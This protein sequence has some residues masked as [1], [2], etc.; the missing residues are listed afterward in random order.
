M[1]FARPRLRV[2]RRYDIDGATRTQDHN[3]PLARARPASPFSF[4]G[5]A[6]IAAVIPVRMRIDSEH[7]VDAS[8]DSTSRSANNPTNK[9][10]DRSEHAVAGISTAVCP[11]VHPTRHALRLCI[12][13]R[14]E[15]ETNS[16]HTEH[17]HLVS[18][19]I[20]AAKSCITIL[21]VVRLHPGTTPASAGARRR[22]RQK[23]PRHQSRSGR[24]VARTGLRDTVRNE[25]IREDLHRSKTPMQKCRGG[26]GRSGGR[27]P[28]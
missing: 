21:A 20:C 15:K 6:P 28:S 13:R 7:A 4:R 26:Q 18:L 11:V 1:G 10:T 27:H 14:G 3:A 8:N 16:N 9:A 19:F 2:H 23:K 12:D 17:S 5:L 24:I 25:R 22:G